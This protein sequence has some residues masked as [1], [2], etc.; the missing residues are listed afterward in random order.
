MKLSGTILLVILFALGWFELIAQFYLIII[1]RTTSITETIIRYFS[2]FTILT[3]LLVTICITAL[4][5]ARAGNF[6]TRPGT[7]TAA[8]VYIT[9]VA[10]VYN[11]ILRSLWRPAG[12]QQFV[13]EL[14][15]SIVPVLYLIYWIIWIPK[16]DIPVKKV[17]AWLIYPFVYLVFILIRG[18]FSLYYPYPFVDVASL[19]YKKVFINSAGMLL[20]FLAVSMIFF[21]VNKLKKEKGA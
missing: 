3:N 11:I 21:G 16:T 17:P 13:D 14:L 5:F 8:A 1:N 9:I 2:F 20:A 7:I 6:F 10:L 12:L 15:H 19:G 18:I 4:L